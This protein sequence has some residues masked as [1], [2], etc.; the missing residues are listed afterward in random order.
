[1]KEYKSTYNPNQY[2]H[3]DISMILLTGLLAVLLT[4][5]VSRQTHIEKDYI[6]GLS[7]VESNPIK[8]IFGVPQGSVLGPLM[9]IMFTTLNFVL[10][11][12]KGYQTPPI[13]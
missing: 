6:L 1:M 10:S 8:L 7:Y 13:G 12:N 3:F 9:L 4:M 2:K 11:K 5:L